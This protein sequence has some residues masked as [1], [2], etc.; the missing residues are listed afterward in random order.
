MT[1]LQ[2]IDNSEMSVED[3]RMPETSRSGDPTMS[4]AAYSLR[5]SRL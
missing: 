5:R 4:K 1:Q 2:P 3:L